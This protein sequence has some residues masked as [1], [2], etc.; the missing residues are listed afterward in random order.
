MMQYIAVFDDPIVERMEQQAKESGMIDSTYPLSETVLLLRSRAQHE[1]ISDM[2]GLTESENGRLGIVFK[3]N[4]SY[5]GLHYATLWD[6]L[7][8]KR[9]E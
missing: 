7:A 8:E 1:I 4:G 2:F 6:W 3:L 5:K 9:D